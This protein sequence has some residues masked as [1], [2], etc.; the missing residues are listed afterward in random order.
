MTLR[1][2]G[3]ALEAAR[4]LRRVRNRI[5]RCE[6]AEDD[7][8]EVGYPGVPP[9]HLSDAPR[10]AWC[11]ACAGRDLLFTPLRQAKVDVRRARRRVERLALREVTR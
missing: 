6:Y 3:V 7:E 8:P 4:L 9:C 10:E 2:L 1:D 11:E 5:G